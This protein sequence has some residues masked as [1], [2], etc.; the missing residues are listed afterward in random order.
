MIEGEK[1]MNLRGRDLLTLKDYTKEEIEYLITLSEKMKY[2]KKN[3]ISIARAEQKNIVL[4]FE[5]ASTRTRCSF[6]VAASD[7]GIATTYIDSNSSQ[8]G[9]KESIADTAK[10]LG[11][12]YDGIEY[13]GHS[14]KI[15]EEF[16]EYAEVPVWN[17]LTDEYHP[18]QMIADLMTMKE[19]F[20]TLEKLKCTY[21]GNA[22]N[23]IG[24]SL[25]IVCAKMGI[26]LTI[27]APK[28]YFPDQNLVEECR[29]YA[30]KSSANIVLT[31]NVMEAVENAD[32]IYTDVW[33]SMGEE[34]SLWEKRIHDL[35]P[36]QVNSKVMNHTKLTTIFMH[37][38]PA[39]HD[40]N[41]TIGKK[42]FESYK[43][44]EME[45]TDDVFQSDRSVVFEQAEN[46]MHSIKAIIYATLFETEKEYKR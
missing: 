35:L 5:K 44:K 8:F 36:Y 38:L 25:L 43:I 17:G 37:C 27:C 14:H 6:E 16:A 23:N 45:V 11:R 20:G 42:I 32:V 22:H 12:I 31:E 18:T 3:G 33:V 7:L 10:V 4:I 13:R 39:F 19:R 9:K 2:Q 34:E 46:R 40:V 30:K 1:F 41:T 26:D 15:V 29:E 28:E 24:N 21:M